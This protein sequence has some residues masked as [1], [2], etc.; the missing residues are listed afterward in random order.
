VLFAEVYYMSRLVERFLQV[1]NKEL[2]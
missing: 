1:P 2:F